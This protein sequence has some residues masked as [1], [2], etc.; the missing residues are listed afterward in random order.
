[1]GDFVEQRFRKKMVLCCR[2]GDKKAYERLVEAYSGYVFAICLS[3]LGHSQDAEDVA[4]QVLLKG[5]T[6]ITTLRNGN[7]FAAWI[8]KIA[9]NLCMDFIRRKKRQKNEFTLPESAVASSPKEYPQ[10]QDALAKLPEHHRMALMLYYF[11]SQNSREIAEIL[12]TSQDAVHTR[13]SRARK[14]LRQ[15]LE[16]NGS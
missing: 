6:D 12:Q 7:V 4:Q 3:L 11:E 2:N 8:G 13:I 1:M 5:F 16:V 10:L 14:Q 9:K 15:L